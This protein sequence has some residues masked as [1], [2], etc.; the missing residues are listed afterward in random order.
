[1]LYICTKEFLHLKFFISFFIVFTIAI[2]PVL[3]MINYAI[4]YDYIVKNF[5]EKR[6]VR[7]S[8]CKGKCFVKKELVKTEKQSNNNHNLKISAADVFLTCEIFSFSGFK[9]SQFNI[10]KSALFFRG[11]YSSEYFSRIFHPPLV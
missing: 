11:F 1:M 7:N 8:D 5:C 4:N 10:K 3:P 9:N 2:R 6:N